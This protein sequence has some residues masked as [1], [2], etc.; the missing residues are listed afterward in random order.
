MQVILLETVQNLGGLG[1]TVK[2]KSGY[3]RNYLFPQGMAAPATPANIAE[4]EA[5]RAELEKQEAAARAEAQARAE[6]LAGMAVSV[7]RKAAEEGKLYGSV[8]TQDIAE[9]VAAAGVEIAKHE[10]RLPE[11]PLRE[12]G[13]FEIDVHLYTDVD[14]TIT[15]QVVA[16]E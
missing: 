10:V 6:A 14:A 7:A 1:E 15:V 11:G 2:V 16:E 8:S 5:R 4:F 3:A 12:L 9:A 13:E